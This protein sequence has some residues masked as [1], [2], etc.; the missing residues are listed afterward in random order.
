MIIIIIIDYGFSC[1]G[2]DHNGKGN[3]KVAIVQ[4]NGDRDDNIDDDE[5][6]RYGGVEVVMIMIR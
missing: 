2:D 1:D 6:R 4:I 3:S 5:L